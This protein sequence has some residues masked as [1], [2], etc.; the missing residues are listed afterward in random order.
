[1][2]RP[3]KWYKQGCLCNWLTVAVTGGEADEAQ[4]QEDHEDVT[5]KEDAKPD[6]LVTAYWETIGQQHH[7]GIIQ[8]SLLP[9]TPATL[10]SALWT[11]M[12]IWI[13]DQYT[14]ELLAFL[15]TQLLCRC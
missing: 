1:M 12:R 14:A 7:A 2:P 5:T 8:Q 10:V 11:A 15:L 9:V 6:G 13:G 4:A 3:A